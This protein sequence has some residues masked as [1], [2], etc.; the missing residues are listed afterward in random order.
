MITVCFSDESYQMVIDILQEKFY[1]TTDLDVLGKINQVY[2]E[3][4]IEVDNPL[5]N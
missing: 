4:G 2:M 3:M 1:A 5:R